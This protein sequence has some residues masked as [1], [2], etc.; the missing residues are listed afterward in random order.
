MNLA[1]HNEGSSTTGTEDLPLWF[2]HGS[3]HPKLNLHHPEARDLLMTLR[4]GMGK[5]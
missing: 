2:G 5:T 4:Y 3:R 1:A